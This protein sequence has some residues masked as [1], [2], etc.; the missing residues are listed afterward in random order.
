LQI[1][2]SIF[3]SGG[4]PMLVAARLVVQLAQEPGARVT[5]RDLLALLHLT[6]VVFV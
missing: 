6:D 2:S 3:A 1:S 4:Q 5:V